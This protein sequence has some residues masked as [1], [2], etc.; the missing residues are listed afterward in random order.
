MRTDSIR[1]SF[2][3]KN[4]WS[5]VRMDSIRSS[6]FANKIIVTMDCIHGLTLQRR[7]RNHKYKLNIKIWQQMLQIMHISLNNAYVKLFLLFVL[8]IPIIFHDLTFQFIPSPQHA[9]NLFLELLAHL[10][11][12][13]YP[14]KVS[15][16]SMGSCLRSNSSNPN[17]HDHL[18]PIP[19]IALIPPSST[20][21]WVLTLNVFE[22]FY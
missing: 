4:K 16:S 20:W 5:I 21:T 19:S 7:K 14:S 18:N 9:C 17:P 2:F 15:S 3:A 22:F 10:W 13:I 1:S 6:F 11:M 8:S 12:S